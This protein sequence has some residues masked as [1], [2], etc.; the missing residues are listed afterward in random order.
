[1]HIL[2]AIRDKRVFGKHFKGRSWEAWFAFFATLFALPMTAAQLEIYKKHT[3]RNTPPTT[4]FL[5]GWL[6]IGRRGGKSFALALVAVFLA[7]F[8][9]WRPFLGPGE[10]GTVMVI[11]ADRRQ[12]RTIMRFALGLLKAVPMLRRQVVSATKESITLANDIVIEIHTAS[13]KTTRGYTVCA[14]LLDE[15]A[16][17]P[18]DE[19]ASEPDVEVLAAIKPAMATVPGAILLAA[20][21]PY[22]RKGA[23][24]DAYRK[25]FAQDNDPVL[26]W[27]AA[28]RDMNPMV[29]QSYIDEHMAADEA[30]AQSEYGGVFRTDIIGLLTRKAVMACVAPN[31]FERG[32]EFYRVYHGFCDPSGGSS[33][34]FTLCVGHRDLASKMLIVDALREVRPPFN[35]TEVVAEFS[36]L[37]KAS[38]ISR[39]VGDRYAGEWPCEA[40]SKNGIYYE[41]SAKPKSDL[42]IDMLAFINSKRV[43]LLDNTRLISQLLG[44]ER[45]VARSGKDS[46]D[47]A[48]GSHDDVANSLAGICSILSKHGGYNL[49]VFS[50]SYRDSDLPPLPEPPK[51]EPVQA[52]GN[53]WKSQ[54]RLAATYSSADRVH[55]LLN[56]I[57]TASKTGF[58]R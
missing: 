9:D 10:M 43:S 53:W 18:S 8:R 41:Q 17:W 30:R 58:F 39:V 19:T 42:Y 31:V 13:F 38:G 20:S 49:D 25:H 21:S 16:F 36:T 27:Q 51:L 44:L 22:A 14:A 1:M 56:A 12:A 6:V 46:I 35:P 29:P 33:D 28:T 15:I 45:R 34:S 47:A 52:N 3:G 37:L 2:Q 11:A 57:D 50:P 55:N 5:E 24:W 54:P 48:P 23:M 40:F 7:C 4:P 32:R 26:V